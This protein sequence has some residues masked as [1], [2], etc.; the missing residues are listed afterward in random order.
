M[1]GVAYEAASLAGHLGLGKLVVLFAMCLPNHHRRLDRNH[2]V[3][4]HLRSLR[5]PAWA[6]RF[7]RS[8]GTHLTRFTLRLR[9]PAPTRLGRPSFVSDLWLGAPTLAGVQ[10]HGS[11]LG[12]TEVAGTK[13]ALGMDA[14]QFFAVQSTVDLLQRHDGARKARREAWEARLAAHPKR[15]LWN[16]LHAE[17]VDLSD[18]DWPAFE[19]GKSLATRKASHAV[20][21]AVAPCGSQ[22]RGRLGRPRWQQLVAR[23]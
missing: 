7:F 19:L 12:P 2:H 8:T 18:V 23:H 9:M 22:S 11:P 14:D 5:G 17:T 16:R 4:R 3:R 20:L 1:E 6:G 13:Q 21:N 15:D 10:F